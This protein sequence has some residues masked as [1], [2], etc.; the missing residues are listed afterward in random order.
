M[1]GIG[2]EMG[3]GED[4]VVSGDRNTK[5]AALRHVVRRDRT[6][7]RYRISSGRPRV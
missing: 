7:C 6:I 2:N 4:Q 3:G 5:L 1:A